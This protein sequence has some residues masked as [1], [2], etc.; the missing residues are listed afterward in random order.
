MTYD[1]EFNLVYLGTGNGSPWNRKI[2]SPDGGDNLFLS[3]IVALD[4]DTGEY[5]WHY[6][7]TPGESWDYN[8]AQDMILVDLALGGRTI[9]ALLHAPK[10]GFFYVLDRSNG[11]LLSGKP[12]T[13]TTWATKI[14]LKSG[15]PIEVAGA[16]YE[17]GEA[18][19]WPGPPGG[20]SWE[21]MSYNPKTGLVYLPYNII[22]GYYNDKGIKRA[23]WR[24]TRFEFSTGVRNDTSLG[25]SP[26]ADAGSAALGAWDPI[27][28]EYRWTVPKTRLGQ[29]RHHDH[30]RRAGISRQ[31]RW[32]VSALIT[33][34]RVR[35]CGDYATGLGISAPA[36]TYELAGKQYVALLVGWGGAQVMLGG[37]LAARHGWEYGRQMRRLLAFVLDGRGQLPKNNPPSFAQP[38][39]LPTLEL[40]TDLVAKGIHVYTAMCAW[41][42][43]PGV[44]S[45]GGAPDLR[46]S[47]IVTDAEAFKR[48]VVDGERLTRGMPEFPALTKEDLDALRHF[49]RSKARLVVG[50]A[51]AN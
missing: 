33:R 6:Q 3:S 16:R 40:D 24:A 30:G 42:H 34:P 7:T 39:Q 4:A 31:C 35:R 43:G 27:A 51:E 22:P 26:P 37:H 20:H 38:L 41:C 29:P 10:N 5:R 45:G 18:L 13:K 23:Q 9:K 17:S 28:G 49:I 14:D 21:P 11:T 25:D 46:A 15:R 1:P 44:V 12:Y 50:D 48:V 36:V 2:R 19:V 8:S 32:Y 47:P